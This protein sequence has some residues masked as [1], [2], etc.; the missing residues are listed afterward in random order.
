MAKFL[1][2]SEIQHLVACD[3]MHKAI[4]KLLVH[5]EH[6]NLGCLTEVTILSMELHSLQK[7]VIIGRV[8]WAEEQMAKR[9]IAYRTMELLDS[10]ISNFQMPFEV[11]LN[12][13][14]KKILKRA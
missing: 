8:T 11:S 9:Q 13:E 12:V 1:N 14:E 10:I 4:D 5:A 7:D 6:R 3:E 2:I